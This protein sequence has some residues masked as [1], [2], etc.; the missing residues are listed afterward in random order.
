MA[1][2]EKVLD[3]LKR[4]TVDLHD[5]RTRLQEAEALRHE[6]I[7]IVGMSCRY[8]GGINS[9]ND[10]WSLVA[11]GGDAIS[12]F[13]ADRGWD[14]QGLY[15]PDPDRPGKC[16]AREGGFLY[17]A[18]KFDAGFFEISPREALAMDPQ[19]QLLLEISWEAL[20]D[21]G[22]DPISLQGEQVGVFAG[23]SASNYVG[24]EGRLTGSL[25]SVATG[26]IAYTLGLEGPAVTVDTACSSSLVA[27]HLACQ[28]LRAEECA[29]ALAGGVAVMATPEGLV[30]FSRQRG[31][32]PDGRCKSFADSADGTGI[33]EGAGMLLVE[34]LSDAR[35]LGHEV[36]AVVRG[37]AIN[38]DGAS[39]GL[40][41][42]NG[43]AQQR[44]IARALAG[45]RLSGGQ[46]DA[47]EGHGTGTT[48]GDPIEVQAL[49]ATYGRDRHEGQPLWLGSIKSNVGHTQ[50][51]AGVAGV[52]KMAM[53][54]RNG[55]LP[56]TLH[57]DRPSRQVDWSAGAVSLLSE[58]TLWPR[59]GQPRRAGVSAFGVSGTNAHVIVEEPPVEGPPQDAAAPQDVAAL[60]GVA[61]LQDVAAPQGVPGFA[62]S[63]AASGDGDTAASSAAIEGAALG[64]AGAADAAA[65]AEDTAIDVVRAVGGA[66]P[67]VVS[68]K[69]VAALRDQARR[70]L[71]HVEGDSELGMADIGFSLASSRA[72]FEQRAVVLGA[73]REDLLGGLGALARGGSMPGVIGGVD[74]ARTVAAGAGVAFLFTGQGA[75]R[76][77]MGQELYQAFPVFARAL[78]EVCA[79]LDVHMERSLCEVLFAEQGSPRA[80]L[81]D[82]TEFTQAG[83]FALEVALFRLLESWGVRP[84]FLLG[85]SIGELAAA[86]VADVFSLG[87]ACALVAARGRLMGALP[88]GGAMV[89]VQAS[90]QE[91]TETLAGREQHV[92]LAAVNGPLAVVLSGDED[93]VM[94][95]AEHW[96]ELGRKTKRLRVTHAFHSPRM[97]PMLQEF[98]EIARSLSFAPPRIP[99]V[100][101]LTGEPASAE[102]MCS[103][104][105]WVAHVRRPVRFMDGMRWL[106]AR[107]VRSFL[108]LGPEGVLSAMGQ[109]CLAGGG[110]E[111]D[112]EGAAAA[113]LAA[114]LRG[115]RPEAQA[116]TAAV[117]EMW[118]RGVEVD[119]G[120]QFV[121][122][123]A[124]RVGLPTY[125]FQRERY[126][127]AAQAPG[128]VTGAG[129]A[130]AN[131]PLLGAAVG[132]ANDRGWLFTSRLSLRS[133]PW[134]AGHGLMDVAVAPGTVYVELALHAGRQVGCELVR[135]LI[136]EAPLV[137]TERSA[138]QVQLAVGEPDEAGCRSLTIHSRP[139]DADGEGLSAEEEWTCN[140]SGVLAPGEG[141]APEGWAGSFAGSA[142]PPEGAVALGVDDLYDRLA[143]LDVDYGPEFR[144]LRAAWRRGEDVFVEASLPED[145]R[146]DTTDGFGLHPALL[147][148]A[149]HGIV[150]S[151]VGDEQG[152]AGDGSGVR[153]PFAWSGVS[154]YARG[155]SHLRARI[156]AT[157]QDTVSVMMAD[158]AGRAVAS[159][160]SLVLRP[161]LPEQLDGA[162]AGTRRSLYCLDWTT[163]APAGAVSAK[164]WAVLGAEGVGLAQAL[165]GLASEGSEGVVFGDLDALAE[166]AASA[167]G[168]GMPEVVFV[169]CALWGSG[170]SNEGAFLDEGT[171]GTGGGEVLAAAR[172]T[173]H[174]LLDLLQAWIADE[175]FS[176]A[177]LVLVTQG[178]VAAGVGDRVSGLSQAPVWGLVRSAQSESPDRF[179]LLD[180]D[181]EGSSLG[182]LLNAALGGEEP[183]LA[184]RKGVVLAPRLALREHP[185]LA[186]AGAGSGNG[187]VGIAGSASGSDGAG[188]GSDGAGSWVSTGQGTRGFDPRGTVLIT[189]GTGGLGALVARHLVAE[190]GVRSLL[191]ASRRGLEAEGASALQS[192]LESLGAR[193]AVAA[194]DVAERGELED[195]LGSLPEEFPLRA[196]VHAAGVV[197]DGLIGSLTAERVDRV[198]APKLDAAWHLHELTEHLDLSAF[199]LFSSIAGVLGGAGQGSYAAGNAFL[200]ALA[201]YRRARGL[202]GL[203]VAW[204]WWAAASGMAGRLDEVGLARLRRSGLVAL[205]SEEGLDL[206]DAACQMAAAGVVAVRLDRPT[207]RA[208][209]RIGSVPALLSA[210]VRPPARGVDDAAQGSLARRLA[211]MS[212]RERERALL[213]LVR[214]ET[215]SVL[216]YASAAVDVQRTFKELGLDSLSAVELRNRL[217]A[218][219]GLHLPA[220]LVFDYPTPVVLADCLLGEIDS[221]RDKAH[222]PVARLVASADE[223]VAIVGMACRYPGGVSSADGLWELVES[224]RDAISEFPVDRGWDLEGLYD[225]DPEHPGTSYT[226]E[227]GFVSDAA[228]FDGEFFGISPREA[229]A[230]DPQQRLLLEASWEA[231]EDA[232]IDPLSLRG[233]QT[234]VFA[235][236]INQ[237]YGVGL[238]AVPRDL[239]GYLTTGSTTSVVSG[240]VAYVFGLEGPA[241]TVDTA[242]SSSLVALHLACGALRGGECS[243]ALAGG[244]SVM[245]TPDPFREFSR[246]RGLAPDGRCKS[247]ADAA[248]GMAW[249][250][251][252]GVVLLERLSDAR[253]LGH[254][255]LAV[256][257]GSAVNQDGA[258][259]GLTAPNG[260]SQQRVIAQALANAGV[261]AAQVDVVEGH[262]TGT[263]LG[264][265]IE[266][267]ALLATYGQGRAGGSPLWL[268]SVKSNLGHTQAAA[269]V[270]GVIKM[271]MAMRHRV[272]P[273]TLHVDEPSRQVDWSVGAVSLL[274][275]NVVWPEDDGPRRAAVSAFGISGTNAHVIL[276]EAPL[277]EAPVSGGVESA[278]GPVAV[279]DDASAG[280][281]DRGWDSA[282]PGGSAVT[283]DP[284]V[285]V[286]VGVVP[287]V[288]AGRGVGGLR[289]QAERL[290]DFVQAHPELGVGDV[291]FSLTAARAA[292][293]RRAVVVGDG[294]DALVGGIGAVARGEFAE[295]VV[296][297]V[298]GAGVGGAVFLFAGQGSQWLGMASE[299]LDDSPVFAG[300]IGL[301]EEALAPLVDWSLEGVLRRAVDAPGLD[302]V[303]VVQPAL[304]AVMVSLAGLWRACGV[305]PSAVVGHSQGEIAAAFVAGGLSLED[306]ARLVVLRSRALVGLMGR[307]GMVSIALGMEA[308]EEWLE[309]WDAVSVA[310]MNGPSSVV[311][312]GEREALDGLLAELVDGGMRAR[313]IPV[314]YASHSSQIE[315]IRRELLDACMGIVPLACGVP[316]YSTV[317]G[318]L[319][320]TARLDG[321]Y[322]YRNLRETVRFEQAMQS[323]LEDDYRAFVEVSPHPVLT[324]A[325]Q[326]TVDAVL[327]DPGEVVVAGSLRREQGGLERF[328][329]SLGEVWVRGVGVD[330]RRVFE[331]SG[332]ER[333]GLPKYAFQRERY[334]LAEQASGTGDV[335]SIGQVTAS[336]PLLGA[337][338][339]LADGERWLFT[340]RLSLDTHPWLADHAAM[341]VVLLPGTAFVDLALR[342]GMQAGCDLLEEL[343]L[344]APLVL[345][346]HGGIQL[347]T[348]DRRA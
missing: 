243:L 1:D 56:R 268:G 278:L 32:A 25:A 321:E 343:T 67:W 347:A 128:D 192:E 134:L 259:N 330:W 230:M 115:D 184:L 116:L 100:S 65:L 338:V 14:L 154:L 178:A 279:R 214:A 110:H 238:K 200:D 73:G 126:W 8:P 120:A 196:V 264:D 323:L 68:A 142:W 151:L 19:Q 48:L 194:C 331:G 328:L 336:H 91:V 51:A 188:S 101:N 113:V 300:W 223:P 233:S 213:E 335:A 144:G 104:E 271:V 49:L 277:E 260:P 297:G 69:S 236:V 155:A 24:T 39:N 205:S 303:D 284:G 258:S 269:G 254:R 53:A 191:L 313:E 211:G 332:A 114:G 252:V 181:G 98:A 176:L 249:S 3:Y 292:F 216:N 117:A 22:I 71:E 231:V 286:G 123:G 102:E 108:E 339:E 15:D 199:V 239:E 225:P 79:A 76:A 137:L 150:L 247:Y 81:L 5:T 77:G 270:A 7:A 125:A 145:N 218:A 308:L 327:D 170:E 306:A 132:L 159:V 206:F 90:E 75:Q 158:E 234:A 207:L 316:F 78:D 147:D 160:Q 36:W 130:P 84:G 179:V 2:D 26:R 245:A 314:G 248:D 99:I 136:Q 242:C 318:G 167:G 88:P 235:G 190:H 175:R 133:H 307:G 341:G 202:A 168:V 283:G 31:L 289:G 109:E 58:A 111:E 61:A 329:L 29:L 165:A 173:T 27:L 201:A 146:A 325:V 131:H 129:L 35:R 153:L 10:L 348:L 215:A 169:D 42:P 18:G 345:P 187:S 172:A 41:A 156:S 30:E 124:R 43:L 70:L 197:D 37:S 310:A 92:V 186:D 85:H 12:E 89:S 227:G 312:S 139:D 166:A 265:P 28:A 273:R 66:V 105:Y 50:A 256:V 138:V 95:L 250:E 226:R 4:V 96:R 127:T 86:H 34:R 94:E 317:T 275:E 198:L 322:W 219:T 305:E 97:D 299:L 11:A 80:E 288:L 57:I 162:R 33:S 309:R 185:A 112:G 193:V 83:L 342:V 311:V 62:G 20:E 44:V 140:A 46:V 209:A 161:Y 267:Q 272:L 295:G 246:Q 149:L 23:T 280:A 281:V 229:L 298:V 106:G 118:V 203:S 152:V 157:G 237:G 40:T 16:Y 266:A 38:Q 135:E 304:F 263:T 21:A 253:R 344:Q 141:V 244:V 210:L 63:A 163:V 241:V 324:V 119:W 208:Q 59:S 294:R 290:S 255:V 222:A 346:E 217:C 180:I 9:P 164:R 64:D 87:D 148:A 340:G 107:G 220:T 228:L 301:C 55:M 224:G 74:F 326:E 122:S 232:S 174:R 296:E 285:G 52:I 212:Q 204:G 319:M 177:R 189:G 274:A 195:L 282:A 60:Q 333:V 221:A 47:V 315:G 6:P 121:G 143:E 103:A 320:D 93:A 171:C 82:R 251:G 257:R 334:W 293:E 45:A 291:G 54:M 276:E 72:V 182:A 240:R 261:S 287:W 337:A 13:P 302:R 262:G 17:D 183:Q